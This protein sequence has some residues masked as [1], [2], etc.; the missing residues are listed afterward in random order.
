[1]QESEV[2]IIL[3]WAFAALVLGF[4]GLMLPYVISDWRYRRLE[5]RI[6]FRDDAT[7]MRNLWL[8][9]RNGEAEFWEHEPSSGFSQK[10][11]PLTRI[12]AEFIVKSRRRLASM[13][14][15]ERSYPFI[16]QD[17]GNAIRIAKLTWRN[18]W[19]CFP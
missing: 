7:V 10:F 17:N 8:V 3:L 14:P 18:P 9:E 2:V 1:M 13:T 11:S 15:E 4:L 16:S 19:R 12:E 5:A 6:K